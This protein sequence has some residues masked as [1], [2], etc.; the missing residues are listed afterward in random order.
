MLGSLNQNKGNIL[1][2]ELILENVPENTPEDVNYCGG[3]IT[4]RR[5]LTALF[6]FGPLNQI[7]VIIIFSLNTNCTTGKKL[8]GSYNLKKKSHLY[9]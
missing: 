6:V 7:P 4:F 1:F 5:A 8:E 9:R 2:T 3:L